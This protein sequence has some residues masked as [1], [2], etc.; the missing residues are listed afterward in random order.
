MVAASW[1]VGRSSGRPASLMASQ[2]NEALWRLQADAAAVVSQFRTIDRSRQAAN[3]VKPVQ[4]ARNWPGPP[5]RRLDLV[6]CPRA[7]YGSLARP[8]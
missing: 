7:G 4:E 5:F 3:Q 1:Q 8:R 6:T 2:C